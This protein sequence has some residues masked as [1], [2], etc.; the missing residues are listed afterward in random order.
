MLVK[1]VIQLSVRLSFN[2][3]N[4]FSPIVYALKHKSQLLLTDFVSPFL[5]PV[6]EI[7]SV[8]PS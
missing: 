8:D 4:W 6:G 7:C 2:D 5:I 1:I 3:F